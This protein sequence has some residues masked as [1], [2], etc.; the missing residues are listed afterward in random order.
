MIKAEGLRRVLFYAI[1]E[2]VQQPQTILP[3]SIP[4]LRR[5]LQPLSAFCRILG[6]SQTRH[7]QQSKNGLGLR[8][9]VLDGLFC[10]LQSF[11]WILWDTLSGGIHCGESCESVGAAAI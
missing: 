11:V 8:A 9:V 1:S 3:I 7:V 5:F 2:F 6:N 4:V 10:Q